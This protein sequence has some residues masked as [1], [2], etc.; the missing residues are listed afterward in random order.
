MAVKHLLFVLM[1]VLG[2]SDLTAMDGEDLS[3]TVS[4]GPIATVSAEP[5]TVSA[6][7]RSSLWAGN[8][9]LLLRTFECG[10]TGNMLKKAA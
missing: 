1:A 7:K 6:V 9:P 10:T 2:L 8:I 4:P 5:M 3:A